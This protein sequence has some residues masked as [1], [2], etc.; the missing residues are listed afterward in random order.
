MLDYCMFFVAVAG[1][2]ALLPQ[3]VQLFQ[4][5]DASSLSLVTWGL[6]FSMNFIWIL[7]GVVHKEAPILITHCLFA[8]LNGA[9]V[10]GILLY[11]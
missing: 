6:F 1:P 3:V 5:H 4:T 11:H 8:I 2:F 7:Y 9:V 10:Y